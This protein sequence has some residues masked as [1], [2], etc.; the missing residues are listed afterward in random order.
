MKQAVLDILPGYMYDGH[1]LLST[2]IAIPPTQHIDKKT[3]QRMYYV[4][5]VYEYGPTVG[6]FIRHDGIVNYVNS[7]EN[8]KD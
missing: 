5:P 6:M 4:R 3:G 1:R 2:G 7:L 8:K